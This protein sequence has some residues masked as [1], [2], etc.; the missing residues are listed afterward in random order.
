[1]SVRY[2]FTHMSLVK[3]IEHFEV[4]QSTIN[5]FQKFDKFH[6]LFSHDMYEM[7]VD[8][9]DFRF[10]NTNK[11]Y[12]KNN[13]I[14]FCPFQSACFVILLANTSFNWIVLLADQ[15][16]IDLEKNY[17]ERKVIV[18]LLRWIEIFA[19]FILTCKQIYLFHRKK[20]LINTHLMNSEWIPCD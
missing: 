10:Q 15:F 1:M 8:C 17:M 14:L 19:R 7:I 6:F 5:F 18:E 12:G 3:D 11:F 2:H 20:L 16:S 4:D 9:V 13:E